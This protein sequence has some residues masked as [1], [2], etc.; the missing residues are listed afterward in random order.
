MRAFAFLTIVLLFSGCDEEKEPGPKTFAAADIHWV[1]SE[2]GEIYEKGE[3]MGN[4]SFVYQDGVTTLEISIS[5][6]EP[7]S[8]HAMHLH[9]GALEEP[10]RH[11]NQGK[12][13]SFC[14]TKSLG[15]FWLKPFAGDV[16]NIEVDE[17]GNGVFALKTDLWSLG[18]DDDSDIAGTVLFIHQN[19][20]D[21]GNECDPNHDHEHGGHMNPKIAGGTVTLVFETEPVQ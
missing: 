13:V 5:G 7:N 12:F 11:W 20:E 14:S 9:Q 21:F 10:G 6:M 19:F 8:T 16:G 15:E 17:N 18:T 2:D 1:S 3:W 4:A